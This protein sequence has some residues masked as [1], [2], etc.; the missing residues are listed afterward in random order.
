MVE[1]LV[2]TK[3]LQAGPEAASVL[4]RFFQQAQQTESS[5]HIPPAF[6]STKALPE[7]DEQVLFQ[8]TVILQ[9]KGIKEPDLGS[10][11]LEVPEPL[12]PELAA[13]LAEP[14]SSPERSLWQTLTKD[15]FL[16]KVVRQELWESAEWRHLWLE[17]GR[18]SE[19][20]PNDCM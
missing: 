17:K 14:T 1:T 3:G 12:S 10:D 16:E 13:A 11:E 4:E 8:A 15:G 2:R 5:D 20:K 9:V 6:W 7:D 19:K 18:L